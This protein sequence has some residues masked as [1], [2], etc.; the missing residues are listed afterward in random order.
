[1]SIDRSLTPPTNPAVYWAPDQ[2]LLGPV[3]GSFGVQAGAQYNNNINT[4]QFAPESDAIIYTG[5]NVGLLWPATENSALRFGAA[6]GYINYVSH[7]SDSGPVVSP[8]SALSW[9]IKLGDATLSVYDQ[10]SYL[11][12]G[13]PDPALANVVKLPRLDNTAGTRITWEPKQWLVEA[14]YSFDYFISPS[15]TYNYLDR[16]SHYFFTR[17]AWRFADKTQAGIEG[18][19]SLTH[20]IESTLGTSQSVSVG[21]YAEWQVTQATFVTARIGEVLNHFDSSGPATPGTSLSSYYLGFEISGTPATFL[22]DNI[23]VVRQIALGINQGS[24]YVEQTTASG[25]FSLSVTPRVSLNGYVTY[26]TGYQPLETQFLSRAFPGGP[27]IAEP[28]ITSERFQFYGGGPTL[29]WRMTD[30]FSSR[31]TYFGWRRLSNLS[32]RAYLQNT[33]ALNLSY[34]FW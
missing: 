19:V 29:S 25:A 18:S 8:D 23:N 13:I 27:I 10:I 30:K 34:T 26:E 11:E 21:P 12:Q 7:S 31:L 1:V 22:S 4:S 17:D 15:P 16:D 6:I 32:G 14:G 3:Q 9:Q 33:V 24:G 5:V 2:A 20:Y 28:E